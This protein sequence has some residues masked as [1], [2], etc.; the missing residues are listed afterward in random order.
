MHTIELIGGEAGLH[1][2]FY[3]P[4]LDRLARRVVFES[5]EG[6]SYRH[7]GPPKRIAHAVIAPAA[8]KAALADGEEIALLDVRETGVFIRGHLLLAASA[9]LWRLELLIDRPVPRRDARIVLTD[10]GAEHDRLAHEAAAKLVRP[11]WGNV[12]VLAGGSAGWAEAGYEIFSG[13]NVPSRP[14]AK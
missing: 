9:P 10:G 7:F 8:L 12:S 13:S 3:G 4:A 11:G 6:G 2:H 5:A 14:S 1:L